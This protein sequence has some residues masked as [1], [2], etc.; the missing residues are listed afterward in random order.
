[1]TEFTFL[2]PCLN[3]SNSIEFCINEI[4][5]TVKRLA[6]NA[7]ILVADNGSEDGSPEIARKCGARVVEITER[8]YGAAII[9]GINASCGKYIIMGDSDGTY[10]FSTAD[11]FIDAL[12]AGS[13]LVMGNRFKGGIEKGAMPFLHRLGVPAL[14]LLARVRFRVSVKDFHC[15]LRAFDREK[16][17]ALGLRCQGMEFATEIIAKFA[18]SGACITEVSTPLRKDRRMGRKAHLRTFRDGFRHLY[19]IAFNKPLSK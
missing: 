7:E 5:D 11:A 3:E 18:K 12:R 8:G 13:D 2:L 19:F 10:D 9:G 4:R 6:L 16:A 15:G 1:M 14:S 17:L